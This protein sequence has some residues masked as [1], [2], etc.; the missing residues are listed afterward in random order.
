MV[1]NALS[2]A[3]CYD[4]YMFMFK[5]S[6]INELGSDIIKLMAANMWNEKLKKDVG[7]IIRSYD[8][9]NCGNVLKIKNIKTKIYYLIIKYHVWS[10]F[11]FLSII[12]NKRRKHIDD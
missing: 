11:R 2:D 5:Q 12:K 8:L 9:S 10:V 1:I 3:E 4:K 7:R 6:T